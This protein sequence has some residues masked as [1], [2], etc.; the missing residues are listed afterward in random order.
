MQRLSQIGDPSIPF[1]RQFDSEPPRSSLVQLWPCCNHNR[2]GRARGTSSRSPWDKRQFWESADTYRGELKNRDAAVIDMVN[3]Y[4]SGRLCPL[5]VF[6]ASAKPAELTLGS[7]VVWADK[8]ETEGIESAIRTML[9]TGI[10]QVVR[11]LHDELD[12]LAGS[13]L[14]E[15]LE[16]NWDRL[17]LL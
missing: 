12:R 9:K 16:A 6:S 2:A 17:V 11:H 7:F 3:K 14:W 15:F 10:P 8:S 5:V 13:Y 1:F 4:R